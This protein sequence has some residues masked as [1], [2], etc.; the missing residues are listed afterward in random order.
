M[1][2]WQCE[3]SPWWVRLWGTANVRMP[4]PAAL[5]LPFSESSK[6]TQRAAS[7]WAMSS[8][9][10]AARVVRR[11]GLVGRHPLA[12]HVVAEVDRRLDPFEERDDP[13]HRRRRDD[14]AG[15][16]R[17]AGLLEQLACPGLHRQ[18]GDD[19][20]LVVALQVTKG[21]AVDRPHLLLDPVEPEPRRRG[22]ADDPAPALLVDHRADRRRGRRGGVELGVLGVEQQ[23]VEVEEQRERRPHAAGSRRSFPSTSRAR[24]R[25]CA[26]AASPSG[27]TVSM[28]T[29]SAPEATSAK[30]ERNAA[31]RCSAV[32][33][34]PP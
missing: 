25:R 17:L 12:G 15:D 28:G 20:G 32:S 6:A 18:R 10:R 9:S 11:V 21:L 26:S 24:I 13:R 27:S 29:R 33:S 2:R 23:P 5:R 4:A 30:S 14:R 31:A 19:V 16:L 22:R 3:K 8:A 34:S 7:W 1:R